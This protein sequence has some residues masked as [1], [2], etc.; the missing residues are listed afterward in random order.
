M[1]KVDVVES[2]LYALQRMPDKQIFNLIDKMEFDGFLFSTVVFPQVITKYLSYD[3]K[4]MFLENRLP[5]RIICPEH[6]EGYY[7]TWDDIFRGDLTHAFIVFFRTAAKTTIKRFNL[8][9]NICYGHRK[10]VPLIGAKEEKSKA[11]IEAVQN[12]ILYNKIINFLFG[13]MKGG[14]WNQRGAEFYSPSGTRIKY[15]AHGMM[16]EIRGIL[17]IDDRPDLVPLDEFETEKD[18][19]SEIIMKKIERI[20]L[21]EVYQLGEGNDRTAFFFTNTIPHPDSFTARAR[22]NPDFQSPNGVYLEYSVSDSPSIIRGDDGEVVIDD[23]FD[24]GKPIWEN[25]YNKEYILRKYNSMKRAKNL[26]GFFQEFYNIPK[27]NTA[28]NFKVDRIREM[29]VKFFVTPTIT[30]IE[31]ENDGNIRRINAYTFTGYDPASGRKDPGNDDSSILTLAK[32][33]VMTGKGRDYHYLI[34]D[35]FFGK[36]DIEEQRDI[37]FRHFEKYKTKSSMVE[38]F[39]MQYGLYTMLQN[40][41]TK[42][43]SKINVEKWEVG[44]N[45]DQKFIDYLQPIV[46]HG[47]LSYIKGCRNIEIFKR[48]L[49]LTK[50]KRRRDDIVDALF[51]A[52]IA[53]EPYDVPA[54]NV[55]LEFIKNARNKNI[56]FHQKEVKEFNYVE[57]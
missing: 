31:R 41:K 7:N 27:Q 20:I 15:T 51:L 52:Y 33:P 24:P 37:V 10:M 40:K 1:K 18:C 11:D 2:T 44:G 5:K 38:T 50:S 48:Q 21:N 54:I 9:K 45:K 55:S 36:I 22:T 39:V 42:I 53:S 25:A 32:I 26:S 29:D 30:Y 16:S 3:D 47:K 13:T 56:L 49:K 6:H 4:L 34:L 46:N 35:I 43:R 8:A 12:Y 57:R 14:T 23:D 17:E 28:A 19:D